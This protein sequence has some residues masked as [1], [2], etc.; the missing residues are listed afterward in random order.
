MKISVALLILS[1]ILS[2]LG[3]LSD[4][5]GRPI[6]G[7]SRMHYWMDASYA[8]TLAVAIHFMFRK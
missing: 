1:L 6:F 3:G 7:L 4:L 2:L 5:T 8:L